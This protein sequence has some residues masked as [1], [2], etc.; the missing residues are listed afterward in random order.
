MVCRLAVI[1]GCLDSESTHWFDIIDYYIPLMVRDTQVS[2]SDAL[3]MAIQLEHVAH[4]S[5]PVL[6]LSRAAC[7]LLHISTG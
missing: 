4:S 1:H 2:S 6:H 5:F 7:R 3:S